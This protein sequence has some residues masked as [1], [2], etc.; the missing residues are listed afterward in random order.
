L[1]RP[2]WQSMA[3]TKRMGWPIASL[4]LENIG[5]C[6]VRILCAVV[7]QDPSRINWEKNWRNHT[8]QIRPWRAATC[9]GLDEST[10]L[11]SHSLEMILWADDDWNNKGVASL[12]SKEQ[13]K[14]LQKH[15]R[16]AAQRNHTTSSLQPSRTGYITFLHRLQPSP[17]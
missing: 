9:A 6:S 14:R 10:K 1:L 17:G 12:G 3:I 13:K 5:D 2:Q 11:H 16:P 4:H 15:N 7:A 8:V